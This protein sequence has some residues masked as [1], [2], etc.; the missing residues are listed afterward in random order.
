ME[1]ILTVNRILA[2]GDPKVFNV[3]L[4]PSTVTV[5]TPSIVSAVILSIYN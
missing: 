3:T 4:S 1:P 5:A 2:E